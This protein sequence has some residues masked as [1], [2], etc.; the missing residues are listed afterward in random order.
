MELLSTAKRLTIIIP[1]LN[2]GEEV[3]N[4]L[5]NIMRNGG[6]EAEILLIN[7]ASDDG[8]DYEGVIQKY[9]VGYIKHKRRLGVAASRD[10]GVEYCRTPFFLLLDGYMRFIL[11]IGYNRSFWNWRKMIGYFYVVKP[12]CCIK[13]MELFVRGMSGGLLAR[14]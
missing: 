1:F 6:S 7:D 9:N 14:G 5:K 8:F 10:E 4:T 3:D 13:R 11:T 12:G 2:E